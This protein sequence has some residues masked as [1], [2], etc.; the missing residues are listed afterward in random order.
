MRNTFSNSSG[1]RSDGDALDLSGPAAELS[2]GM[3][4]SVDCLHRRPTGFRPLAVRRSTRS[5]ITT[6][7]EP[8]W[9]ERPWFERVEAHRSKTGLHIDVALPS[10]VEVEDKLGF[11][12]RP[13]ATHQKKSP[14]R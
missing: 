9:N 3:D 8:H 5:L 10:G 12:C 11:S 1:N 2:G 7:S 14:I 6:I 4:S 13:G